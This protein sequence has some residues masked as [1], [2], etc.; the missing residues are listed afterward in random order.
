LW[1]D[2]YALS[3]PADLDDDLVEAY[4]MGIWAAVRAIQ[5]GRVGVQGSFCKSNVT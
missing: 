5:G 4:R 2:E 1:L 3:I